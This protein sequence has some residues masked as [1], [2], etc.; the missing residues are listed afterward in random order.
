MA[1]SGKRPSRRGGRRSPPATKA[2]TTPPP[3]PDPPAEGKRGRGRPRIELNEPLLRQLA[4]IN[5]THEEIAATLTAAGTPISTDTLARNFADCIE[6]ER[7]AGRASLRRRQWAKALTE[8]NTQMLKWLGKNELGQ[9][10]R[11][12][13][14]GTMR[15]ETGVLR[16]AEPLG[17][18]AWQ[19]IAETQQ[20]E[21]RER[22]AKS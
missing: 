4:R 11:I 8:G 2:P 15:G 7:A 9:K 1:K 13:F 5:C 14:D 17:L 16:T 19:A 6:Q 10:E 22:T 20:A 3:P 21:L 18:E 12:E